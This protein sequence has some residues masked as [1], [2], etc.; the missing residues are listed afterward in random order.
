MSQQKQFNIVTPTTRADTS[1]LN[2]GDIALYTFEVSVVTGGVVGPATAY[3]YQ[4]SATQSP[5]STLSIPFD[6][7]SP[8][9]VP[10]SGVEYSAVCDDKDTQGDSSG[11]TAA[12]TW[13]QGV[14]APNPPTGFSVA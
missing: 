11:N 1:P 3:V 12:I 4:P 8:P 14:A 10:T 7:L 2:V 6:G 9:F 5:G 13:T